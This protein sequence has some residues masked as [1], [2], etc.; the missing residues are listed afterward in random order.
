MQ[1]SLFND[2]HPNDLCQPQLHKA[3]VVGSTGNKDWTGNNKSVFSTL[4]ASSHSKAKDRNTI[5]MQPTQK[6]LNGF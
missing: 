4:G 1:E 2:I 3:S 6:L 5:F